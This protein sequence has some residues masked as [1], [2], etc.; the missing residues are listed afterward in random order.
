MGDSKN[1]VQV[2]RE[3][4]ISCG[5][6]VALAPKIFEYDDEG[7]SVVISQDG[8]TDEEKMLAAQSCP[9]GAIVLTDAETGEQLWPK[10]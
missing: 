2:I 9:T 5:S 1:K 7:I 3:K 10:E 8:N 4:C 6:C